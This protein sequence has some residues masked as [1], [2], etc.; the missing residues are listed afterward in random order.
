MDIGRPQVEVV[1]VQVTMLMMV[2]S[3]AMVPAL[4]SVSRPGAA[5]MS[6]VILSH[7]QSA[8]SSANIMP[9]VVPA[10][11][12]TRSRQDAFHSRQ[13]CLQALG[14]KARRRRNGP[15]M[16]R[17]NPAVGANV[18]RQHAVPRLP[19]ACVGQQRSHLVA[20]AQAAELARGQTNQ[21]V[22]SGKW[23][24]SALPEIT[25]STMGELCAPTA[26]AKLGAGASTAVRAA[27]R[28]AAAAATGIGPRAIMRTVAGAQPSVRWRQPSV[29]RRCRGPAKQVET[30]ANRQL[31]SQRICARRQTWRARSPPVFRREFRRQCR[32]SDCRPCS[33]RC[34]PGA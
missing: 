17:Q 25:A 11:A 28:N 33:T 16:H 20:T 21:P 1:A 22:A 10:A 3:A 32:G 15:A 12:G 18:H 8:G 29:Q 27:R 14:P 5:K 30:T 24:V 2:F 9:G 6:T 23:Q 4:H 31:F 34:R 26:R 19:L 13:A 7:R